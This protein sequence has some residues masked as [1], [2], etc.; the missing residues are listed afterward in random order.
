MEEIRRRIG[1]SYAVSATAQNHSMR[2]LR[3]NCAD[4]RPPVTP[5]TADRRVV[6]RESL[7]MP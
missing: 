1:P 4:E 3:T 2:S 6:R 7:H 5:S